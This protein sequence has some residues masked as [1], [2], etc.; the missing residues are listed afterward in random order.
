MQPVK[1]QDWGT[2][3][4]LGRDYTPEQ[5]HVLDHLPR[6]TSVKPTYP[7]VMGITGAEAFYLDGS[8]DPNLNA[9]ELINSNNTNFEGWTC[10]IG[11]ESLYVR[12][13][14][15]IRRGNCITSP[16][17]GK[18]QDIENVIWPIGPVTCRQNYCNC[19]TDVFVS[20]QKYRG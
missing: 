11:L 15:L 18:I 6:V 16:F 20:K 12:Y 17:I 5:L 19:S 8:H 13:D 14:G 10:N 2:G 3:N 4:T 9:Q 7:K 1:I